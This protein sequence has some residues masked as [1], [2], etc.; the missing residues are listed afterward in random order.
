[1]IDASTGLWIAAAILT[2]RGLLLPAL[3]ARGVMRTRERQRVES[4]HS[5][6]MRA[7]TA[8]SLTLVAVSLVPRIGLASGATEHAAI[9]LIVLGLAIAALRVPV[10]FQVLG[11]IVAENGVYLASLGVHRGFPTLIELGL[12]FDLVVVLGVAAAFGDKI[13][14]KF[15]TSDTSLLRSLRD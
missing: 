13:H 2:F 6:L 5:A 14:E 4:E 12:L 1:A 3:L 10:V 15:G 9:A 8:I 11:F 7:V